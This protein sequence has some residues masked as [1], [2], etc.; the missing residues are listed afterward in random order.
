MDREALWRASV[1]ESRS[2]P[3][4]SMG[5][6]FAMLAQS[7]RSQQSRGLH[8]LS[9]EVVARIERVVEAS[10]APEATHSPEATHVRRDPSPV[11]RE[12]SPADG[13][14]GERR[15]MGGAQRVGRLDPERLTQAL[16]SGQAPG[17]PASSPVKSASTA[18]VNR[19]ALADVTS[20]P[21]VVDETN[22]EARRAADALRREM[23]GSSSRRVSSTGA[24]EDEPSPASPRS[25]STSG[26][27]ASSPAPSL[28][29]IRA[30]VLDC[31]RCRLSSSRRGAVPGAGPSPARLMFVGEG[32]GVSDEEVGAPF[33]GES[34]ELL[35]RMIQA[36]GLRREEVYITNIVKCV[37]PE[38]RAPHDDE[39]AACT[40]YLREELALVRPEVVVALGKDATQWFLG[41]GVKLSSVRGRMHRVGDFSL[42][43]TYHPTYLLHQQAA[44]RDAWADLQEVMRHLGLS[45]AR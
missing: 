16:G 17:A 34:G 29:E 44:K 5:E 14:G 18:A 3:P 15:P 23:G 24:R 28:A 36:M 38:K 2:Q 19:E 25:P 21:W 7:M 26:G 22:D 45:P 20:L 8:R 41:Q 39:L 12:S 13:R 35:T 11:A 32:P 9:P 10:R 4:K 27:D 1:S 40:R 42:M 43:P 6:V 31:T 33:Q 30:C 37:T